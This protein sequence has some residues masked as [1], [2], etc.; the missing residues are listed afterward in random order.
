MKPIW[1]L[2]AAVA[3]ATGLVT[4]ADARVPL[5]FGTVEFRAESLAA[6]HRWRNALAR[7]EDERSVYDACAADADA[8]PSRAVMAWQALLRAQKGADA[9]E[10]IRAVNR[11]VNGW[12]YR[13]D[14]ANW[15]VRDYWASPLEFFAHSGD[16]EDYA[17]TKYVSLRQLG[18]PADRLRIVVLRD[19]LRDLAHA[20]LAVYIDDDVYI[21]DNVTDAVLPHDRIAHYAPYYSVNETSRWVHVPPVEHMMSAR[22]TDHGSERVS[23]PASGG[24]SASNGD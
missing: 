13:E 11:F 14:H 8:C 2:I 12:E 1:T 7:I 10:Q 16:C 20:V 5:L 9:R 15:G 17:I 4:Q 3:L 21:L 22:A 23:S 18:F 24:G 19:Q 6:L